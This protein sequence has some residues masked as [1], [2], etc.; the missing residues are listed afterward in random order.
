MDV[1]FQPQ[2]EKV[3]IANMHTWELE[4]LGRIKSSQRE[5]HELIR[6]IDSMADRLE[7]RLVEGLLYC[8]DRFCVPDV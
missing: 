4:I 2:T 1:E 8:H 7:F 6:L 3:M 5:G